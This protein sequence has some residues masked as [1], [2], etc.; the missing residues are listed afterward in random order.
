MTKT[1]CKEQNSEKVIKYLF[2]ALCLFILLTIGWRL[3]NY[4]SLSFISSFF[5]K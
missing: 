3:L 4:D 5:R 1:I 2:Y